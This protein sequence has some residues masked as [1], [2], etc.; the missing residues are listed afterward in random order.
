[1]GSTQGRGVEDQELLCSFARFHS[2]LHLPPRSRTQSRAL[3][4]TLLGGC[5]LT[6]Y[7]GRHHSALLRP[8]YCRCTPH[9][10]C[11]SGWIRGR[12]PDQIRCWTGGRPVILGV[13]R[14]T[15]NC[16]LVVCMGSQSFCQSIQC[17]I[18]TTARSLGRSRG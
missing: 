17:R 16:A 18:Q 8:H 4:Q 2:C 15:S 11:C 7:P 3:C 13:D 14:T 6:T 9:P 5:G 10:I 12:T 1:M